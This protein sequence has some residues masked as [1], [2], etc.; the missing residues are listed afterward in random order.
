VASVSRSE[1]PQP[2]PALTVAIRVTPSSA[3]TT[4]GGRRADALLVR[5]TE[6]AVDGR[7]TEAA[8]R[9][10]AGALGVP[11]RS[12]SLRSGASSRDKIVTVDQADTAVAER[13]AGLLRVH[14]S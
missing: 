3:R 12:V 13:L 5:V 6:A 4:V 7:A 11:R 14:T 10:L 8:L 2:V 9:A 1:N